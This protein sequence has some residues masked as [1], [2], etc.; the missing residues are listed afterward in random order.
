MNVRPVITDPRRHTRSRSSAM[1][2]GFSGLGDSSGPPYYNEP[3]SWLPGYTATTLNNQAILAAGESPGS[4]NLAAYPYGVTILIGPWGN[5]YM[6]GSAVYT[7]D[8]NVPPP[9]AY[10]TSGRTGLPASGVSIKAWMAAYGTPYPPWADVRSDPKGFVDNLPIALGPSTEPS[11]FLA[12]LVKGIKKNPIGSLAV[13][14]TGGAIIAAGIVGT[15]TA[16]AASGAA[17]AATASTA[18]AAAPSALTASLT[19]GGVETGLETTAIAAPTAAA[20]IPSAVAAAPSL[21]TGAGAAS[22]LPGLVSAGG[23]L[24][25]SLISAAAGQPPLPAAATP[26]AG[27]SLL[28]PLLIGAAVI[29]FAMLG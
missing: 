24:A 21:F 16:A 13:L 12:Q 18:T 9:L 2:M 8:V 1:P 15:G 25:P 5:H 26:T 28:P 27:A 6:P 3:I 7:F 29:L 19:S 4:V 11:G 23:A 17:P 14:A 22:V 10:V 20:V